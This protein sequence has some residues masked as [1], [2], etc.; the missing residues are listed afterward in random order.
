MGRIQDVR[1]VGG[2]KGSQDK[3]EGE[4]ETEREGKGE[5]EAEVQRKTKKGERSSEK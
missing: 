4:R 3:G 5:Q 2:R 1:K